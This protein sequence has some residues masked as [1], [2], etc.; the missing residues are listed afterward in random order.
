MEE[1]GIE[2]PTRRC[3]HST[4]PRPIASTLTLSRSFKVALNEQLRCRQSR[5][6]GHNPPNTPQKIKMANRPWQTSSLGHRRR[7]R[8]APKCRQALAAPE[9]ADL[10]AYRDQS[11]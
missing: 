8:A 2:V 6:E 5:G 11:G 10:A 1:P 4:R 9:I 3:N 7:S